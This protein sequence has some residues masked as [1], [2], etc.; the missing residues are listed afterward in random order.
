MTDVHTLSGAYVL[1]AL[2]PEEAA[3]FRTHLAGC[4][5]CRQEVRELREA[6]A[7]MGAAQSLRPPPGLRAR[8]LAAA[9]RT[10]QEPP[11]PS[12]EAHSPA[13]PHGH[14]RRWNRLLVAAAAAVLVVGGAV[15]VSRVL[16]DSDPGTPAEQVFQAEDARTVDQPTSNGGTLRV[17][18]SPSRDEMAVDTSELPKLAGNRVYQMWTIDDDEAVV[19]VGVFDEPGETAAIA[20]PEQGV[21]VALTIEP[22]G[23]SQLPTDAPIVAVEPAAL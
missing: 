1:D 8:V 21:T 15:G 19:S 9:D 18:V 20:L 22:A 4:P 23:G 13:A 14:A 16:D 12:A 10:P 11:T 3:A 7:R 2:N 6:A 5:A 17:A